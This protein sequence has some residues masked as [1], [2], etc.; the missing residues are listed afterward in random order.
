MQYKVPNIIVYELIDQELVRTEYIYL[1]DNSYVQKIRKD[2][3]VETREMID[4]FGLN[5]NLTYTISIKEGISS[6]EEVFDAFT[7]TVSLS[8]K[9]AALLKLKL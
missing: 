6:R 9:D 7:V 3:L 1:P 8:K 4:A 5:P 2:L